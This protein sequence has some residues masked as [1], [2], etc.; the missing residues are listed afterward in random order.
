MMSNSPI[1]TKPSRNCSGQHTQQQQQHGVQEVA[2]AYA[3][4]FPSL[5][6]DGARLGCTRLLGSAQHV[7]ADERVATEAQAHE[8][9]ELEVT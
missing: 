8:L 5:H 4:G 9:V 3:G 7:A 1:S 2:L 6:Y